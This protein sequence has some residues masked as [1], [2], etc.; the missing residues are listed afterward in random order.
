MWTQPPFKHYKNCVLPTTTK[1]METTTWNF[2]KQSPDQ[3]NLL[4]T[5]RF[6]R[7]ETLKGPRYKTTGRWQQKTIEQQTIS[8]SFPHFYGPKKSQMFLVQF[9]FRK[10]FG[11]WT[12]TPKIVEV[13][14]KKIVFLRPR[15]WDIFW[16]RMPEA[17]GS[18]MSVGNPD[19][20][21]YD[22]VVFTFPEFFACFH[23][24]SIVF[25]FLSLVFFGSHVNLVNPCFAFSTSRLRMW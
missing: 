25:R 23:L 2:W 1:T 15:W 18:G 13:R 6:W 9:F 19:R 7:T 3:K 8:R 12:S 17:E 14:T 21:I 20:K 5:L 22:Y 4:S 24:F 16:P 10:P 11:S